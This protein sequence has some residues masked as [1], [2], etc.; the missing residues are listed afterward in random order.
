MAPVQRA[1]VGARMTYSTE[2]EL[3]E[4]QPPTPEPAL[5]PA[6]LS[7]AGLAAALLHLALLGLTVALILDTREGDWRSWWMLFLALDFPVSLGV[8]PVTWLVPASG[9]GPLHDLSNFWWPL[10]YHGVVGTWWWY[11]VGWAA[12]RRIA[13]ALGRRNDE[14]KGEE[15]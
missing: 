5:L 12:A 8:L 6:R 15:E 14:R 4:D 9:R 3:P 10:A 11:V 1:L 2:T 7:R 13:A